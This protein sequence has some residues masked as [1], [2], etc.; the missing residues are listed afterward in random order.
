MASN[1]KKR[2]RVLGVSCILAALIIASSSFAWFT[3]KDEVTNRLTA[4]ADYGVSIVESF[5]P[6]KNWLPGQEINKD[7]Y[8]VNTGNVDAFV[9]ETITGVLNYTYEQTT[10]TWL[11]DCVQLTPDRVTAIDGATTEE[12]GGFLAWTDAEVVVSSTPVYTIGGKNATFATLDTPVVADTNPAG[13]EKTFTVSYTVENDDSTTTVYYAVD[14]DA[15]EAYVV[16]ANVYDAA[17]AITKSTNNTTAPYPTGSVN[18]ARIN[19]EN[20]PTNTVNGNTNPAAEPGVK[21]ERWTPPATGHYIFRRSIDTKGTNTFENPSYTYAGYYFVKAGDDLGGT[22]TPSAEDRYYE[23]VIGDDTHPVAENNGV[24]DKA[25]PFADWVFDVE[26]SSADLVDDNGDPITIGKDGVFT[27]KPSIRYVKEYKVENADAEFIY[28]DGEADDNAPATLKVVYKPNY[29]ASVG[30]V[31]RAKAAYDKAKEDYET[32][33]AAYDKIVNDAPGY[34]AAAA[35]AEKDYENALGALNTAQSRY[36][37]TK[38]DY[39]YAKKVAKATDDLYRAA[40][41]RAIFQKKLDDAEKAKDDAWNNNNGTSGDTTDDTGVKPTADKLLNGSTYATVMDMTGDSS[42]VSF[43]SLFGDASNEHT[44]PANATDAQKT[45]VGRINYLNTTLGNERIGSMKGN[46]DR[47]HDLWDEIVLLVDGKAAVGTEGQE[48]Y[49][50]EVLGIKDLLGQ[51]NVDTPLDKTTV[52]GIHTQLT[53]KLSSLE[54]KVKEYSDR[55]ADLARV[56]STESTLTEINGGSN[57]ATVSA[58]ATNAKNLNQ[59]AYLGT[60]GLD[61]LLTTYENNWQTWHDMSSTDPVTPATDPATYPDNTLGKAQDDWRKAV[62]A[63]NTAVGTAYDNASDPKGYKQD[64]SVVQP[65]LNSFDK[66]VG[67]VN[68][69]TLTDQHVA[70]NS[71]YKATDAGDNAALATT[72]N[73]LMDN[74]S[75][76]TVDGYPDY[77]KYTGT[78]EKTGDTYAVTAATKKTMTAG[79]EGD[80]TQVG[81][82]SGAKNLTTLAQEVTAARNAVY[83]A[84]GTEANPAEGSALEKYNTAKDKRDNTGDGTTDGYMKT[85]KEAMEAAESNMNS[86][87]TA[88]D[89]AVAG[90]SPVNII[91]N[92][93]DDA[94]KMGWTY[95]AQ[96]IG[97]VNPDTGKGNE[98]NFYLNKVLKAGE[99]SAKLID[100][101]YLDKDTQPKAYKNLVFD[102]NVGMDSIQV[103]YDADQREYATDAVNSDPNFEMTAATTAGS[104]AVTWTND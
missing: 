86:K 39:E 89:D 97:T 72:G 70:V 14:A 75:A 102:L 62:D 26:A 69:R 93:A 32:K 18:S 90:A 63:Y 45:L 41:A 25:A 48:G 60:G 10:D 15:N 38:A 3:S 53:S 4:N 81:V 19:D 79:E 87:K 71:S 57:A 20:D 54:E 49:Q 6:P 27:T 78:V 43:K 42:A 1:S 36:D 73:K 65:E 17:A 95:D 80:F 23:I 66:L 85:A 13:A 58:A 96:N 68:S 22:I 29:Q 24:T 74:A 82:T 100:S 2:R 47:M 51:L 76:D 30:D 31:E 61:S 21:P 55:Y 56:A 40:D 77:R 11:E 28:N 50:A 16:T 84:G 98:A 104:D 9:K 46:M 37:Q 94:S 99:T 103:T 88:W 35:V 64:T 12:A 92:L 101:V 33:K 91:I 52:E 34:D 7:V 44:D 83:G 8:A 67:D 59:T 5:V